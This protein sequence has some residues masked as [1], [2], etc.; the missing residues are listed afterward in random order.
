MNYLKTIIFI[1][2]L[3]FIFSNCTSDESTPTEKSINS[4]CDCT[5][6]VVKINQQMKALQGRGNIET[7]TDLV[8]KAGAAFEEAIKCTQKNT[9]EKV[10]KIKLKKA[11]IS[12]CQ[13]E[14]RMINDLIEKL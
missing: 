13:V 14:E 12:N 11:L 4:I 2:S 3:A 6:P 9:S 10:D 5:Q 8:E 7:I 1:F